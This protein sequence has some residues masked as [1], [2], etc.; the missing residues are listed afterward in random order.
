MSIRQKILFAFSLVTIILIGAAFLFIFAQ[1][2]AYREEE[3]LQRQ[4]E[5]I[6]STL[7]VL[8]EVKKH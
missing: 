8:T 1:F 7:R 2:S 3:F 5:R 4:K 6:T